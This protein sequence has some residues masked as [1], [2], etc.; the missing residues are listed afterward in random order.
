MGHVVEKFT[1]DGYTGEVRVDEDP[2]NPRE[3]WDN[4]SKFAF[5][6]KRY[7]LGDSPKVLGWTFNPDNFDGWEEV[8]KYLFDEEDA[9]IVRTVSMIDHSGLSIHLGSPKCRW[10]GGQIGYAY[11]TNAVMDKEFSHLTTEEERVKKAEE[12]I[13]SDVKVYADY[14]SGDV[15]Y[16]VVMD[17]EGEVVES[18][19]GYIGSD[20]IQQAME[21]AGH[22]IRHALHK[23]AVNDYQCS[24]VMAL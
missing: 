8:E 13:E 7:T 23:E 14:V 10:D 1:Q 19:G 16:Y 15:Y 17:S 11:I 22:T 9:F 24:L 18:I 2:I 20:G 3:D 4:L 21:E 5:S 12:I 6:H